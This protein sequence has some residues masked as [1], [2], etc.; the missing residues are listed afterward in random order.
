VDKKIIIC[1][2]TA[3][4]K[5]YLRKRLEKRGFLFDISYTSREPRPDETNGIDYHFISKEQFINRILNNY[6]YEWIEYNGNYYGTGIYEWNNCQCF[7]METDGIK[8]IKPEDRNNCFII[9]LNIDRLIRGKRMVDERKWD[10]TTV[11]KR[12]ITDKGKF[13]DF[14][15]YD[16]MITNPN[17]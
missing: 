1:G 4:G 9:Y 6:F 3:S 11:N 15:D 14:T 13:K 7:I 5:T 10:M 12:I 8:H 17:F 16:L 2:P